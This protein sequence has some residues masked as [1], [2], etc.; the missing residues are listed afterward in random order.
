MRWRR[1][2]LIE[3]PLVL[4]R[5]FNRKKCLAPIDMNSLNAF[6]QSQCPPITSSNWIEALLYS[7]PRRV[8][9]YLY[10]GVSVTLERYLPYLSIVGPPIFF[11]SPCSKQSILFRGSIWKGVMVT[12]QLS[13]CRARV[14]REKGRIVYSRHIKKGATARLL[15]REA[16]LYR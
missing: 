8:G 15:N 9:P 5:S 13:T 4:I 6:P 1:I 3:L 14:I 2:L 10:I 12:F 11:C 16:A 7:I